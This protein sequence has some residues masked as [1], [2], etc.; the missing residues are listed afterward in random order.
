MLIVFMYYL[1][2]NFVLL[3]LDPVGLSALS[4]SELEE[5]LEDIKLECSRLIFIIW[6]IYLID[7]MLFHN[8]P[9]FPLPD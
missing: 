1:L 6:I 9:F 7:I 5:I 4:E 8:Q 2:T 3:Q